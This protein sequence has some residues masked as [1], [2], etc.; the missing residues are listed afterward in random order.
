MR[1]EIMDKSS[2][3]LSVAMRHFEVHNRTEGKSIRTVEWYNE[4]LGLLFRWLQEQEMPTTLGS[5]DEM[6]VREFIVDL[7]SR[8]GTKNKTM[9]SHSVYNRVNALRSFF[10]GST[11]RVI[12]TNMC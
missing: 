1:W 4:V 12:P 2:T 10:L 11:R 8:P 6:R 5:I 3:D 7:Q 9:S